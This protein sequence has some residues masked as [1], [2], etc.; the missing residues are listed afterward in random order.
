MDAVPPGGLGGTFGGNPLSCAAA[1]AVLDELA[2][3]GFLERAPQSRNPARS[4][5]DEIAARKPLVGEVRG[6]GAMLA[7][8]WSS[9][10]DAAGR[11]PPPRSSRG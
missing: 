11:S 1:I 4:R 8:S 10:G 3:P 7:S 6:L 2:S 5:L 9:E